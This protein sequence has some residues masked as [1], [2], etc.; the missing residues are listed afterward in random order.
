V[1]APFTLAPRV[2][3]SRGTSVE[4]GV[5]PRPVARRGRLPWLPVTA[6]LAED[7]LRRDRDRRREEAMRTTLNR[8][9]DLAESAPAAADPPMNRTNEGR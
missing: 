3:E 7:V 9:K 6:R 1:T 4:P 2:H 8:I 5:L